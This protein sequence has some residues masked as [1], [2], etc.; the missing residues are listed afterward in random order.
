[1]R[2]RKEALPMS[3]AFNSFSKRP[4]LHLIRSAN[5]LLLRP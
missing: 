2:C 5:T 1:M 3:L 4:F